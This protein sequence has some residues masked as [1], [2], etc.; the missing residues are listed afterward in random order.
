MSER[1]PES[2][3]PQAVAGRFYVSNDSGFTP[4]Q[5]TDMIMTGLFESAKHWPQPMKTRLLEAKIEAVNII[6]RYVAEAMADAT[7]KV[8]R[9]YEL[10]EKKQ[11]RLLLPSGMG[12]RMDNGG[13]WDE[14]TAPSGQ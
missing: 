6:Q 14:A 7:R 8:G 11:A 5:Y 3:V 9:H 10:H 1:I 12:Q 2:S 13:V 4:A